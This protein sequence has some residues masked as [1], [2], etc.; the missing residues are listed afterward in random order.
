MW[1]N[2][3]VFTSLMLQF[4][5]VS[6]TI[7][8][9]S[10]LRDIDFKID[11]GEIVGIIGSSGAG[12]SSLF[13]LLIGELKPTK[14][15]ILLDKL[16]L[17]ELS[18]TA[19]QSYRR[20]IGVVFQDFRLLPQKTVFENV[21]FALEVC[22]KD[23]AIRTK[24]SELL[25]LVDLWDRRHQF[26]ESLSGGEKQRVAIARALVHDPK[27][28]IADEPTGNLDSK[29]SREIGELFQKLHEEKK[30]TI[31]LA[32]HDPWFIQVFSPR[33]IRLEEGAILFDERKFSV[34]K[35]FKGIL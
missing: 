29:N 2:F 24:V 1:D 12:K 27:I 20:Q 21:A 8:K 4:D 17:R 18:L 6:L 34:Q 10:V 14:G 19:I 22:G 7:R 33:V 28:L 3:F 23:D 35:A 26:P 32:T 13:R 11:S 31:L 16:S 15:Q 9:K 25:S 30:L 5:Q